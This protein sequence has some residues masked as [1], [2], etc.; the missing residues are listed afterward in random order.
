MFL[1]L[2]IKRY[3][4]SRLWLKGTGRLRFQVNQVVNNLIIVLVEEDSCEDK[5]SGKPN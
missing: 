5:V 2:V 1:N 4:R 3:Q